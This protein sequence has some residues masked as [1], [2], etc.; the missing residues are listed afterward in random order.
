GRTSPPPAAVLAML[1]GSA[2]RKSQSIARYSNEHYYMWD[3]I[4][5]VAWLNPE[6]ITKQQVVYM[7]V[8]LDHGAAYGDTLTW[9]AKVKP[10][11]PLQQVHAQLDLDLA[12]F[13]RRFIEL[14][15]APRQAP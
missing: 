8:N 6:I 10:E 14:M 1:F 9:T 4:A 12:K 15:K 2:W 5:S 3:E 13:N 7:D 11:I